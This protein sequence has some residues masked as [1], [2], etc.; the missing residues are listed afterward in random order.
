[1]NEAIQ[2]IVKEIM[3]EMLAEVKESVKS[4]ITDS[5]L[6]A[7][8]EAVTEFVDQ[9]K[10]EAAASSSVWVKIRNTFII[11][12]SVK[13]IWTFV[14]KFVTEVIERA[15]EIEAAAAEETTE[16]ATEEVTEET[17]SVAAE[18]MEPQEVEA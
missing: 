3:G 11:G 5:V 6:P 17:G 1:M 10:A 8:D 18:E 2:T 14:Q 13:L 4:L 9:Q 7:I 16:E 15:D 12:G